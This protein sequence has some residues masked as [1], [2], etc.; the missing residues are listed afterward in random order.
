MRE[1][2]CEGGHSLSRLAKHS[3]DPSIIN[4]ARIVFHAFRGFAPQK[5]TTLV[6]QRESWAGGAIG[7]YYRLGRDT[8]YPRKSPEP[9]VTPQIGKATPSLSPSSGRSST[10]SRDPP[11]G[12]SICSRRR[13]STTVE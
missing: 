8:L 13:W 5:I 2:S 12:P 11:I 4:R 1:S 6:P 7:E 9:K 10:R 3:N